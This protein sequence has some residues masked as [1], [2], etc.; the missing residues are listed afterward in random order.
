M[1]ALLCCRGFR[2]KMSN[3]MD[4]RR[5]QAGL[6]LQT[7]I[8]GRT[9]LVNRVVNSIF[10]ETLRPA[11]LRN[12]QLTLLCVVCYMGRVKPRE[13]EK[14]LQ[15]DASTISRNVKRLKRKGWLRTLPAEDERSHYVALRAEGLARIEKAL[16]YWR[17]A[18]ERA[19]ELLGAGAESLNQASQTIL[20]EIV[21]EA[22]EPRQN[23]DS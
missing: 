4:E 3:E 23:P 16:P 5:K 22:P 20:E 1:A 17:Q 18:Q 7:C 2:V 10:D 14:I 12:G 13:L 8:A 11:G 9:R 15:M 21:R 6:M 19:A